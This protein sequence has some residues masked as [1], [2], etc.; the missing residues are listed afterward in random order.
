[1]KEQNLVKEDERLDKEFL[2]MKKLERVSKNQSTLNLKEKHRI[3][4]MYE[5]LELRGPQQEYNGSSRLTL[6]QKGSGFKEA[7]LQTEH[8][9][10]QN[11]GEDL[12]TLQY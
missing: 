8:E 5:R 4:K 2:K 9:Q 1:M 10:N 6:L 12:S 11:I 7:Y 3:S